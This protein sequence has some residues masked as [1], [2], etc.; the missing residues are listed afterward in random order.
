M[1]S[2]LQAAATKQENRRARKKQQGVSAW[3]DNGNY[4]GLLTTL[5]LVF[6]VADTKNNN[7]TA[8]GYSYGEHGTNTIY[9]AVKGPPQPDPK[10]VSAQASGLDIPHSDVVIIGNTSGLH[11][12]TSIIRHA[13]GGDK[14]ALLSDFFYLEIA[15]IGKGVCPDCSGFMTKYSIPHTTVRSNV[16]SDWVN[17]FSGAH[18]HGTDQNLQYRKAGKS[19]SSI[20]PGSQYAKGWANN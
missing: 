3:M 11:A 17:P 5:G 18:F 19:F 9:V 12:E 20:S 15:C 10:V 8:I 4:L 13:T 2:I 7:T 16:A 14:S 1:V 6:H